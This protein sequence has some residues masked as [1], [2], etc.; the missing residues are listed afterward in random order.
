M[1]SGLTSVLAGGEQVLM[2]S[3]GNN[4]SLAAAGGSA[5]SKNDPNNLQTL[6]DSEGNHADK[7]VPSTG[8]RNATQISLG[9]LISSN[10]NE[11][12]SF[13]Y[14]SKNICTGDRDASFN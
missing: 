14:C 12:E 7:E 8:Y 2:S 10:E 5:T 9:S 3:T 1:C 4:V 13:H 6:D 11:K